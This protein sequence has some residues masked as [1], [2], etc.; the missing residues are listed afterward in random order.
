MAVNA[1]KQGAYD[2]LEKPF[3]NEHILD[4]VSAP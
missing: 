4:V 1:L 2:F 3:N